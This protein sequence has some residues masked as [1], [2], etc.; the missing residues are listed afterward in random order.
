[1]A[2]ERNEISSVFFFGLI[3]VFFFLNISRNKR[4]R[5]K[6]KTRRIGRWKVLLG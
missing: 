5:K 3:F 2:D 6:E 1:M 4:R